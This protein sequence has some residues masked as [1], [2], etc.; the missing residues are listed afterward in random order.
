M[1]TEHCPACEALPYDNEPKPDPL[2]PSRLI[3]PVF[4]GA[5]GRIA[6]YM[7]LNMMEREWRRSKTEGAVTPSLAGGSE[8]AAIVIFY[9]TYFESRMERLIRFGLNRLPAAVAKDLAARY[10]GVGHYMRELYYILFGVK[11]RDDLMAV[12]AESI[13]GHLVQVQEAR[14][15]F[16]HGDPEALNDA[17]VNRVVSKMADEHQ[18]WVDVYNRRIRLSLPR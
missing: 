15:K 14:N 17:L 8:S 9:W 1:V 10:S 7:L 4:A 16:I 12:D 5:E 11:Y 6:D 13:D 2:D 18:A 3:Y